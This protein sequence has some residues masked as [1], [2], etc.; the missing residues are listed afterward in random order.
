VPVAWRDLRHHRRMR[1]EKSLQEAGGRGFDSRHLHP[2]FA[3]QVLIGALLWRAPIAPGHAQDTQGAPKHR[4]LGAN[5][6][7]EWSLGVGKLGLIFVAC[8]GRRLGRLLF[9]HMGRTAL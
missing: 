9:E 7:Q 3:T 5:G 8:I 6:G 4:R 2:I 1:S